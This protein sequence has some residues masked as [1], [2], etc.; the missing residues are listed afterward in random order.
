MNPLEF[1][2]IR[3]GNIDFSRATEEMN[4]LLRAA[5]GEEEW[6]PQAYSLPRF[7]TPYPAQLE[8]IQQAQES[9]ARAVI[10]IGPPGSGKSFVNEV[11]AEGTGQYDRGLV[12][13]TTK[14]L[15][16]QYLRDFPWA[17]LVMGK[18]NYNCLI[19]GFRT[20]AEASR[21][22]RCNECMYREQ[23]LSP[24]YKAAEEADGAKIAVSNVAY[25]WVQRN[26]P[27][28]G[29]LR[30]R[31]TIVFDEAH[32]LE[33][34]LLGQLDIELNESKFRA[35]GVALPINNTAE[36]WTAFVEQVNLKRSKFEDEDIFAVNRVMQAVRDEWI[37]EET[38]TGWAL[39]P[40]W[41]EGKKWFWPLSQ[42]AEKLVFSSATI[43]H[44]KHLAQEVANEADYE[45]IEMPSRFPAGLRQMLFFPVARVSRNM[46]SYDEEVLA[47][48][49]D[50]LIER[51]AGQKGII[52]SVSYDLMQRMVNRSRNKAR[53]VYHTSARDRNAAVERFMRSTDG[54]IISPS[55]TTGYDFPYDHCRFQIMLKLP[56][57]NIGDSRVKARRAE[58]KD[59]ET[60]DIGSTILQAYGR[61][62]RAED[63]WCFTYSLDRF[64]W[65][66]YQKNAELFPKYFRD[67]VVPP[68]QIM[69]NILGWS[70]S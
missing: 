7:A 52:H 24:Y 34:T 47:E 62:M 17:R 66:W 64:M 8:A 15:Q 19:P 18:D 4:D 41:F 9:P 57:P 58:R 6:R 29:Y 49:M 16:E 63:D 28:G 48:N 21:A 14:A 55:M 51:H 12:L 39:R 26:L 32:E 1:E 33:K 37:I 40:T 42:G 20:T 54:V 59:L 46:S 69:R 30:N 67:A 5:S 60:A 38:D 31:D 50:R 68:G 36:E 56:M 13:C 22:R 27:K 2:E 45:V 35:A 43:F 23:H 44:P 11:I 61:G 10:L 25:H 53:L 65:W 3:Y 70:T